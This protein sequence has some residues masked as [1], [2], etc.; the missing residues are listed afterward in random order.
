[1][2][3]KATTIMSRNLPWPDVASPL[4]HTN[5]LVVGKP[6][7]EHGRQQCSIKLNMNQFADWLEQLL[8]FHAFLKYG[9]HLFQES[10]NIDAYQQA[11]CTMMT[12]MVKGFSRGEGT[13]GFKLQKV[14]ECCHFGKDHVLMGPPVAHNSDTGERGLKPWAKA[15]AKTAQKRSD[16]VFKGQVASNI[17]EA[18][19][20]HRL[21]SAGNRYFRKQHPATEN[22]ESE[23]EN[24]EHDVIE[25]GGRTHV[26]KQT[27]D[28]VGICRLN[29]TKKKGASATHDTF[30]AQ[31]VEWF[32]RTFKGARGAEL[33]INLLTEIKLGA[34]AELLRAHPNFRQ[35][36]PWYDFVEIN[37]GEELGCYPARCACFFEWPAGIDHTQMDTSGFADNILKECRA[38]DL[39]VLVQESQFQTDP[40]KQKGSLLYSHYTLYSQEERPN[41]GASRR[42]EQQQLQSR[43]A[44]L[45]CVLASTLNGRIFVVDPHPTTGDV[46]CKPFVVGDEGPPPFS[47]IWVKDRQSIWPQAFLSST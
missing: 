39:M 31:V 17:V 35:E 40:E 22:D 23:D 32:R 24:E 19:T 44:K 25:G 34:G 20:L 33:T 45:V 42:T 36:G 21:Y 11:F 46:F 5:R 10:G 26:Y 18:Q 30:P 14:L 6:F 1:M 3:Y 29:P 12:A 28:Q 16:K 15:P 8:A 7:I 2:D 47:I 9:G 37:Y 41:R 43:K 38:G 27:P 4:V 13:Q